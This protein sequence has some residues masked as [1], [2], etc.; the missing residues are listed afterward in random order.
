[1]D[2]VK[3]L[4]LRSTNKYLHE[5]LWVLNGFHRELKQSFTC[6]KQSLKLSINLCQK[7]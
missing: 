2:V 4:A 5:E 1:L 6:C 7:T 3:R